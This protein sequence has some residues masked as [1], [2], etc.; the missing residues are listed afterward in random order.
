MCNA[1]KNK[2]SGMK[3]R[4][5][6]VRRRRRIRGLDSDSLSSMVTNDLLPTAGG[7]LA[8]TYLPGIIAKAM[9]KSEKAANYA[10][11]AALGIGAF[12]GISQKGMLAK[13]GLGMATAGTVGVVQDLMDGK[14]NNGGG[15][16]GLGLLE[17]G[18]PAYRIAGYGPGG[19]SPASATPQ[20]T[21]TM[22]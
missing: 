21:V 10:N 11:Y 17:Y 18:Q 9:P 13:V 8:A 22:L 20:N 4:K 1:C 19:Q 12:L 14:D 3:K 2:I 16:K 15:T 6:V 7:Y 5:K